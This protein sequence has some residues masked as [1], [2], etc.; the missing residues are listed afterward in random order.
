MCIT[1]ITFKLQNTTTVYPDTA[2]AW[3]NNEN[4]IATV[5]NISFS[6]RNHAYV[7]DVLFFDEIA[8]Q[9]VPAF[10]Q[11]LTAALGGANA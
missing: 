5:E 1:N 8:P 7:V 6:V 9:H 10:V 4:D 2:W 3:V 11:G